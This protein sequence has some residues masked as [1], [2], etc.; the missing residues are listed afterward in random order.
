MH[1]PHSVEHTVSVRRCFEIRG[2]ESRLLVKGK[3]RKQA[4]STAD[5]RLT[6]TSRIRCTLGPLT[7][8]LRDIDLF[9]QAVLNQEPWEEET[10]LV[11]IHWRELQPKTDFV[12]GV[13]WHDGVA[14]LHPPLRRAFKFGVQKLV[15]AGIKVV[16]WEPYEHKRAGEVTQALLFPDGGE[17]IREALEESGEPIHTLSEFAL[18]YAQRMNV[19]ENW[20]LNVERNGFRDKYQALMKERGVNFILC[21]TYVGA[22]AEHGTAHYW[23][24]TSIWNLLDQPAIVFP[25][26][27]KVEEMDLAVAN[28]RPLN[29]IDGI[30]QSK[31]TPE[32]F[33]GA[34]L[35]FQ[36]V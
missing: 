17:C 35:A 16:D 2:G 5:R 20:D 36:L 15:A 1:Q 4:Q 26:G 31:Y 23:L 14:Q 6:S 27:L 19:K 3:N 21:P 10:S 24:Y 29:E 33:A 9:Q 28:F 25:S 30:E 7:N 13:M 22:A 8:S 11:P 34:P 18:H 32:K 12:V